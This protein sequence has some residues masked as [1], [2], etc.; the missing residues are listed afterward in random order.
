MK[1][2]CIPPDRVSEFWDLAKPYVSAACTKVGLIS[3]ADVEK[4]VLA[5]QRL[6]WLAVEGQKVH[7][8]IVTHLFLDGCSRICEIVAMGHMPW[9]AYEHFG[10]IEQI[11]DFARAEECD[12]MR[13]VGRQG[14][15]RALPD[16]SVKALIMERHL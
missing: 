3:E 10:L 2:L 9:E 6:L 16:Y 1:L 14:W 8:A 13:I 5:G 12:L 4:N 11:E 7:G 15:K